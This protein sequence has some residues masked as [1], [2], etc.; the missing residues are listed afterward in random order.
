MYT[1]REMESQM[2]S[3]LRTGVILACTIMLAG[4]ILYLFR[5][6]GERES[7]QA[8]HGEPASLTGIRGIWREVVAG[9]SRGIIQLSVLV[10]IATPVMRGVRDLRIHST[11]AVAF[12]R[13]QPDRARA[14]GV[15]IVRARMT[16]R[17][18]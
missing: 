6:G 18:K 7:Y 15:W 3:L 4:G 14:V 5:H 16:H 1:D 10:M 11:E 12:H 17:P 8:F 13:D 2:G 9:E